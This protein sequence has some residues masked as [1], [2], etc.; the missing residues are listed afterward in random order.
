MTVNELIDLLG[1]FRTVHD[2]GDF[3]VAV[4]GPDGKYVIADGA[5]IGDPSDRI[6]GIGT[7]GFVLREDLKK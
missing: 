6:V 1:M 4:H 2:A 7:T 3:E 5:G